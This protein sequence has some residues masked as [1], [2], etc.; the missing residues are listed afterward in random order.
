LT[1]AGLESMSRA[2][3]PREKIKDDDSPPVDPHPV[4][5]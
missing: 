3:A 4:Q 2:A 1:L 5:H